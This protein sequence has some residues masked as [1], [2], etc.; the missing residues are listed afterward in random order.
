MALEEGAGVK[1]L[2]IATVVVLVLTTLPAVAATSATTLPNGTP[3]DVTVD[4]PADGTEYVLPDGATGVDVAVEGTASVGFGEAD[5]TVTYVLDVSGSVKDPA[6]G[7]CGG[8]LNHDGLPDSILDCEIAGILAL[9][10]AAIASGAVDEVGLAVY[11]MFGAAADMTPAGSDDPITAPDADGDV[12]TVAGSVIAQ[13]VHAGPTRFAPKNVVNSRT[14]FASGLS[15]AKTIVDASTNGTNIVVF[16]SD[17]Q[18]NYGSAL[19]DTALAQLAATGAVAH[20]FA[21]GAG[22]TCYL[23]NAG[24]L[25]EIADATGGVCTEVEDPTELA[26]LLAGLLAS[27]L[28][29]LE[30]TVD[31]GTPA[32][33]PNGDISAPLP[34]PGAVQVTY[35]TPV[36]GLGLGA[37]ELCVTAYGADA[38]GTGD[39]GPACTTVYVHGIDL[40]PETAVKDLSVDTTHTVTATIG[41]EPGRVGGRTVTFTVVDGPNAGATGSGT[42]APDGTVPWTYENT[43]L[44]GVDTIEACFTVADPTG[45]TGCATA[46]V[47]WVD[48]TPPVATCPPGPNPHGDTIPPAGWSS[49]PGPKGG[50]NEDGFYILDASDAVDP[51]PQIYVVDDGSGHVFGPYAPGTIVKWTQAPG[52]EPRERPMGSTL[53]EAGAVAWHLRGQGDMLVYAVDAAGNSSDPTVCLVPPFPK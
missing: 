9:N 19:F 14:N 4:A 12:A 42:T 49:P 51:N 34:Q 38:G 52:A 16:L 25:Q 31:G 40:A 26:G 33:I 13:N 30:L 46:T 41:G 22:A 8:D 37:H 2:A 32:V 1:R 21:I 53:G 47:E 44:G 23:G 18:S 45:Q 20:T 15:A 7:Y 35:A 43:G 3:I 50:Q 39:S 24:A 6:D 28:D 17:G 29:R 11:G 27:S 10:D 36:T 48:R 5:T